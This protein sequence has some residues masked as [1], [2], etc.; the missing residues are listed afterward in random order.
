MS[1]DE[2]KEQ[3]EVKPGRAAW[4]EIHCIARNGD[5]KNIPTPR[6]GH[7]LSVVGSNIFL[8]GG[9]DDSH[10]P[11]PNN[12][13]FCLRPRSSD[14]DWSWAKLDSTDIGPPVARWRHTANSIG[15]TEFLVFGGYVSATRDRFN[16]V[17]VFNAVTMQWRQPVPKSSTKVDDCYLDGG[18][19]GLPS[20]RGAHATAVLGRTMYVFGGHGGAG[21][22]LG[23]LA[24]LHTLNLDTWTWNE[25]Q[26]TG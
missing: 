25:V 12:D 3:V 24:D 5:K 6:C 21:F 4:K 2:N 18:W 14:E 7:S 20:P 23:H 1:F 19:E 17:W 9:L 15:D 22:A 8:F 11:G 16:D 13:L 10:P 26:A